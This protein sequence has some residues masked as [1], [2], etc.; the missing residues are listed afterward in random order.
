MKILVIAPT[1]P[2]PP[3]SGGQTR[4]LRLLRSLSERHDVTLV[5]FT[6]QTTT[7][8]PPPFP[9]QVVAVPW[10]MP[11]LYAAMYNGDAQASAAAFEALNRADGEPW[12]VSYNP[13]EPLKRELEQR[14]VRSWDLILIEHSFMARYAADLLPGVPRVL[15]LHNVHTLMALREAQRAPEAKR[16]ALIAEYQRMLRYEAAACAGTDWIVACSDVDARAAQSLLNANNLTIVPNGVDLSRMNPSDDSPE[17][18]RLLFTGT[19]NYE[20]NVDA[21]VWFCRL[22]LP[23]I[24]RV[25]PQA[26]LH[27]AGADPAPAVRDLEGPCVTVHGFVPDMQSRLA[28]ASVVV[29]PLRSGGGTRLKILDAAAC[30]KA[31]VS[32]TLG[33]EGL[34]FQH[35]AH[36]LLA[37]DPQAFAD[38]VC[39]L[40]RDPHERRRLGC[41][42]RQAVQPY[43]WDAICA[44]FVIELESRFTA[45]P[46]AAGGNTV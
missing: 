14:A 40:L 34:D 26:H 7:P 27:I 8:P 24:Q 29:V 17:P 41:G 43:D 16:D 13:L 18:G 10:E 45:R 28:R 19:M 4:T 37:D 1:L 35:A 38:A 21:V 32:T 30:G 42:A 23:A 22:I 12:I 9:M 6:M 2:Y 31:I 5:C 39:T 44:R 3:I 36:L 46:L 11:P 25:I 15:D 20:P 33:A